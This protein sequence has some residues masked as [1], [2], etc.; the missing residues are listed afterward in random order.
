MIIYRLFRNV[1]LLKYR[2]LTR[3][4]IL[5]LN[6]E[7]FFCYRMIFISWTVKFCCTKTYN[8]SVDLF[9]NLSRD[10]FWKLFLWN[11]IDFILCFPF[12]VLMALWQS[13]L[14]LNLNDFV[15]SQSVTRKLKI[16]PFPPLDLKKAFRSYNEAKRVLNR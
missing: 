14:S 1:V 3:K 11:I 7:N 8:A 4:R 5:K 15:C 10:I 16:K 13:N 12:K 9:I 2:H 6:Q